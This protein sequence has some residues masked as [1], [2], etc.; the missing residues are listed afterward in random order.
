MDNLD[1]FLDRERAA[2]TLQSAGKF[3][4][5]ATRARE[6]M[7][8]YQLPEPRAYILK[9]VQWAVSCGPTRVAISAVSDRVVVWHDGQPVSATRVEELVSGSHV[10]D[11]L[12][13]GI[14]G[15]FGLEPHKLH[16][17]SENLCYDL[18][19]GQSERA[20]VP[21]QAIVIEG[22]KRRF[23][24]GSPM[25]QNAL[26]CQYLHVDM[27]GPLQRLVLDAAGLT[28]PEASLVRWFCAFAPVPISLNGRV[29]NRPIHLPISF[30]HQNDGTIDLNPRAYRSGRFC[31]D[32]IDDESHLLAPPGEHKCGNFEWYLE[33]AM[34]NPQDQL[35]STSILRF[36]G[37][38]FKR[39]RTVR[40]FLKNGNPGSRFLFIQ[41]GV[42]IDQLGHKGPTSEYTLVE[43]SGMP[44]SATGFSLVRNDEYEGLVRPLLGG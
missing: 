5:N 22:L 34:I 9:L 1:K 14:Y 38:P 2:G 29:I 32:L 37:S 12:A 11:H 33:G 19:T 28:R 23:W 10:L 20:D 25:V 39:A 43:V 41:D 21:G 30:K 24:E 8:K 16:L 35:D 17:I 26:R 27:T 18:C 4:L 44:V 36:A 6:L 15:A 3:T 40:Y 31:F 42:V 13:R 7:A